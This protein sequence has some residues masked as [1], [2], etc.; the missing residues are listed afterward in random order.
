MSSLSSIW[1][2]I[3]NNVGVWH[4]NKA[5][6]SIYE[7]WISLLRLECFY[8]ATEALRY[9][10]LTWFSLVDDALRCITLL[11]HNDERLSDA[12]LPYRL[13]FECYSW[14][15]GETVLCCLI[16]EADQVLN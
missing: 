10:A 7:M 12:V 5:R 16:Q 1:E 14:L 9:D 4:Y 13:L 15:S 3:L 8:L 6:V 2:L 11:S